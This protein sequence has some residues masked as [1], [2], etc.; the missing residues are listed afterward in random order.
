MSLTD[1]SSQY[2]RGNVKSVCPYCH[3]YGSFRNGFCTD[4][5]TPQYPSDL[6]LKA[7]TSLKMAQKCYMG[8]AGNKCPSCDRSESFFLDVCM[9]CMHP[10]FR[11][12]DPEKCY[13]KIPEKCCPVCNR[14]ESFSSGA[15]M[16]CGNA[17]YPEVEL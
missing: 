3:S 10:Q 7:I 1:R 9:T 11:A 15:C 12:C 8:M 17:Q 2:F 13:M 16:Y 14:A 4:D 6:V 5:G